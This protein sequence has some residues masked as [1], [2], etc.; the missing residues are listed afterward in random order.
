M[1]SGLIAST[2]ERTR[3]SFQKNIKTF[4]F[5]FM[6]TDF[7]RRYYSFKRVLN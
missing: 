3:D 2:N 7:D 5:K 4:T 1:C 6:K